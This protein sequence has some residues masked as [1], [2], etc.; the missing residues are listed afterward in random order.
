MDDYLP[1]SA[2]IAILLVSSFIIYAKGY[3]PAIFYIFGWLIIFF[4]S[5]FS[6]FNYVDIN[7]L[8]LLHI[9]IP[10][11]SLVFSLALG[12]KVQQIEIEKQNKE[13]LLIQ[14]NKLASTGEMINNIA[15]QWRQPLTHLSYIF[16]NINT[17][18]SHNK[19]DE[20]YL[21]NKSTEATKQIEYMS[22]TI[23]DFRNFYLLK[24]NKKDFSIKDSLT[25]TINIIS[26]VIEQ[27]NITIS[28]KG[29]DFIING[30]K[31]EF[32]QVLLN[33]ITNAK[34]ALSRKIKIQK[35]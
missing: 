8:Y 28:I 12:Y 35:S 9:G 4:V 5:F 29:D 26:S 27:N 31:S 34:D 21:E 10:I 3:K 15:H 24:Q 7:S 25:S 19:L 2:I 1:S 11:E 6:E 30:Y 22:N 32:S 17:A 18:F 33:I 14:Q 13:Q 20:K 16:M 23:E